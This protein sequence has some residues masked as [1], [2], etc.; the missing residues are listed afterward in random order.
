MNCRRCFGCGSGLSSLDLGQAAST[1]IHLLRIMFRLKK[2]DLTFLPVATRKLILCPF[3]R[4][5]GGSMYDAF[6]LLLLDE[7]NL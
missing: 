7:G 2:K 1:V 5:T 3:L 4:L 6:M